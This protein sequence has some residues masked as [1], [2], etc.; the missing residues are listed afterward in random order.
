MRSVIL[1][2]PPIDTSPR[3]SA[4]GNLQEAVLSATGF[5]VAIGLGVALGAGAAA[6]LAIAT[7]LFQTNFFPD[8]T[9]V[10]LVVAVEE[11]AP[12][13]VQG[14]PAFTEACEMG[15]WPRAEKAISTTMARFRI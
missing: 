7:P 6:G 12:A 3:P 2:H 13:F 5:T 9:H 14:A 1:G 8:L 10:N 15:V 4:I 11:V